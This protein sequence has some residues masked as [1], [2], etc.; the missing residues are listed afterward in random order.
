MEGLVRSFS[1]LLPLGETSPSSPIRSTYERRACGCGVRQVCGDAPMSASGLQGGIQIPSGT[2]P[3]LLV[4][5]LRRW[6]Y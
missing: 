3:E 1:V 4:L 2:E 6:K 5:P